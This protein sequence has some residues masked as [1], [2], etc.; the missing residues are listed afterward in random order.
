MSEIADVEVGR[1]ALR[2]FRLSPLTHRLRSV[3]IAYGDYWLDG[4]CAAMCL[5]ADVLVGGSTGTQPVLLFGRVY[6]NG[7]HA[8]P[9]LDCDCG[10]YGSLSIDHLRTQYPAFTDDIV[11]VIAAEGQTIIGTR[12]LRTQFARVVAYWTSNHPWVSAAA[13][14]QFKEAILYSDIE[15]ML[16]DYHLPPASTEPPPPSHLSGPEWWK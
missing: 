14:T 11:A 9:K 16:T 6:C 3:A 13:I 7:E 4:T 1:F 2:T 15:L 5:K 8:A 10:I 12:G